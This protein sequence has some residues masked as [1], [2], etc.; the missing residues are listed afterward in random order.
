MRA[1][2]LNNTGFFSQCVMIDTTAVDVE[3]ADINQDRWL[4]ARSIARIDIA[5]LD[6]RRAGS[7]KKDRLSCFG[8]AFCRIEEVDIERAFE[9][10]KTGSIA[11]QM[12][13]SQMSMGASCSGCNFE[14]GLEHMRFASQAIAPP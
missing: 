13:G 10:S 7:V 1:S 6:K 9:N 11:V 14:L 2:V 12:H 8:R 5:D 4:C 3:R